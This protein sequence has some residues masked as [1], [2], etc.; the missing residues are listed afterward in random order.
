MAGTEGFPR[1]LDLPSKTETILG[2]SGWLV[3][4]LHLTSGLC[5]GPPPACLITWLG[6]SIRPSSPPC[7]AWGGC[8]ETLVGGGVCL[9]P[10]PSRGAPCLCS[11]CPQD[12]QCRDIHSPLS[13]STGLV[14]G[15]TD[16]PLQSWGS[17]FRISKYYLFHPMGLGNTLIHTQALSR[18]AGSSGYSEISDREHAE[19]LTN[20]NGLGA[21]QLPGDRGGP[22]MHPPRASDSDMRPEQSRR[23]RT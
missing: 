20:Q 19:L 12:L 3:T 4:L 2:T 1:A 15:G 10:L 13:V 21:E 6:F 23:A 17:P 8:R 22:G 11:S 5:L 18:S 16:G 14:P 7:P 9:G